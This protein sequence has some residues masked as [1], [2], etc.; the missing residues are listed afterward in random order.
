VVRWSG[1]QVVKWYDDMEKIICYKDL[2]V[3]KVSMDIVTKVYKLTDK[4]PRSEV[5]G[6]TNQLRRCSVSIP[7]NIAEGSGR[8]NI[9]EYIHFLYISKGSLLELE[10]QLEISKR[11]GYLTEIDTEA[12]SQQIKYINS[13]LANLI[14]VL[15]KKHLTT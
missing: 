12:L 3:W 6:L 7:S 2:Q 10:T 15:Q 5:Y 4:F 11:I 13:M 14:H 1:D 8:K 9:K